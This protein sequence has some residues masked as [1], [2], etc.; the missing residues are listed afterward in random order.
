MAAG[1]MNPIQTAAVAPVN[2]KASQMLGMKFA[3]RKI[4]PIRATV[5]DANLK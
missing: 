2:W 4:T 5:I 1:K 3:P